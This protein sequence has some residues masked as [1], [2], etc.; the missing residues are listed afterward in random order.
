MWVLGWAFVV[1]LLMFYRIRLAILV[2]VFLLPFTPRYLAI[3]IGAEGLALTGQRVWIGVI[4]VGVLY[5]LLR[6][7][8]LRIVN[9]FLLRNRQFILCLFGL[10]LVKLFSTLINAPLSALVYFADEVYFSFFCLLLAAVYFSSLKGMEALLKVIFYSYLVTVCLVIFELLKGAPIFSGVIELNIAGADVALAGRSRQGSYRVQGLF[11]GAL[12]LT[13]FVLLVFPVALYLVSVSRG[14]EKG[15]AALGVATI[16]ILIYFTGSR[17]GLLVGFVGMLVFILGSSWPVLA[18]SV[19]RLL[20][21]AIFL[22]AGY[23]FI[24]FYGLVFEYGGLRSQDMWLYEAEERSLIERAAQYIIIP[25]LVF[26]GNYFGFG[27]RQNYGNEL[28]QIYNLDSYYMRL[29]L[30]GGVS[31]LLLFVV[32][33]FY[34]FKKLFSFFSGSASPRQ[35]KIFA[36]GVMFFAIFFCMKFFLSQPKNNVYFYLIFGSLSGYLAKSFIK[37][38][39][40]L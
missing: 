10:L 19:R 15:I 34:A 29:L 31:A 38:H 32:S 25:N 27:L 11:D 1:F 33:G 24:Y 36:M 30:E 6:G 5:F 18:V 13:E 9:D 40:S 28:D 4:S 7:D 20:I 26:G 39:F 2:F 12:Q 16:P 23:F 17:S 22:V 8:R 35:R 37:D 21:L 3:P 14:F